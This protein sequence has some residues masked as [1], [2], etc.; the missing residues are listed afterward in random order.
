MADI[1]QYVEN[2]V[3]KSYQAIQLQDGDY[4]G[5]DGLAYCGQCRTRK[6]TRVNLFGVQVT[7]MCLCRCTSE[8]RDRE[9]RERKTRAVISANR[10]YCFTDSRLLESTFAND[11]GATEPMM[12]IC[13]KYVENFQTLR[14][15][16][17]GL[18]LYG[19]T[20]SGKSYAAASIANALLDKCYTARFTTFAE[21]S[22]DLQA[23]IGGK[24]EYIDRLLHCDLLV[25][26]DFLMER[27]TEYMAE[28]VY[29]VIDGR[30]RR[31]LPLVVTTNA[32]AE[33]LKRPSTQD[34]ARV[35]SRIYEMCIPVECS[36][37]DRRRKVLRENF[38]D[39]AEMLG[40][41]K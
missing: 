5:E 7:P 28:I 6:Q 25:L 33:E 15:G 18:L 21:I 24:T 20:G 12:S 29:S 11:D 14:A 39:Y 17:K 34:R 38:T 41:E 3:E 36:A 30:Y 40:I 1:A 27:Q 10:D 37:P 16:G 13:R 22:N 26:D 9:E 31:C 23:D 19:T 8:K 2:L 35:I 32:T 4:I